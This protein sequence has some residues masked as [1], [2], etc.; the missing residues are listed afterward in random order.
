MTMLS[1]ITDEDRDACL[2]IINEMAEAG[3]ITLLDD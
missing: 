1:N 2:P 3:E